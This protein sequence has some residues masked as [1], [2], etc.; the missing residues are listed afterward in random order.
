[1]ATKRP[2]APRQGRVEKPR[3]TAM[4]VAQRIVAEIVS[5][6][7]EPGDPLLS[8]RHMLED[9]GV[10]RGT[11]REALRFLELQGVLSIRTG[12]GGGPVVNEPTARDLAPI[13]AMFLQFHGASFRDMLDARLILEPML[14][15]IAAKEITYE[16]LKTLEGTLEACREH[17]EIAKPSGPSRARSIFVEQSE[18]F[19][20][21]ITEAAGNPVFSLVIASLRWI[22]FGSALVQHTERS[23]D[24]IHAE[25]QEI[26]DALSTRDSDKA[27]GCMRDHVVELVDYVEQNYPQVMELPVRWDNL[28]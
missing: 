3:K 5:G 6:A 2:A 19:H 26:F 7:Y 16:Q 10:A 25:H 8:E 9:Y 22:T 18:L 15:G 21:T 13:I 28:S 12:P 23:L 11:L 1:M 17:L 27:A 14:A 24:L 20:A 4:L